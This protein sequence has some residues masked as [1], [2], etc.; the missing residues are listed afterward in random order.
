VVSSPLLVQ[1][2]ESGSAFEGAIAVR[3]K[4]ATTGEVI[5]NVNT[6]V[7]QADAGKP[8]PFSATLAF[9]APAPGTPVVVEIIARSPRDGA[10]VVLARQEVLIGP[11]D[12]GGAP[13][14]LIDRAVRDLAVRLNIDVNTITVARAEAVE[15]A[16]AALE[17]PAPDEAVAEVLTPGYRIVLAAQGQ[18]YT[19]HADT[20][21]RI[22][23]CQDSRPAPV[24]VDETSLLAALRQ[25]GLAVEATG[26][27]QQP[28]LHAPG[29]V[30]RIRGGTLPLPA[31][32]Q[33]YAYADSAVAAE[34]AAQ[35]GPDGQ[36]RTVQVDWVAPP[37][38]FR[39]D[40]VLV[41]YAGKDE[42]VLSLLTEVL[43]PQFA[44]R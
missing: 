35:I 6:Q 10:E 11:G 44:P 21:G 28:F 27:V 20:K 8:G 42:A 30:Y 4:N 17:C 7:M 40:R 33:S 1:G 3:L 19:Y 12:G 24:V 13:W 14:Q 43:G 16:N 9:T 32:I 26:A 25:R 29:T 2:F 22:V 34:D 38:F 15:W 18:Q 23:L 39:R 41:I 31:E 37:H 36:P 5:A